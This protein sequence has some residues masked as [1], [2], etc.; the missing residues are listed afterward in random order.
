MYDER[1]GLTYKN[2]FCAHCN[3]VLNSTF[4]K[5][6]AKCYKK[7][8]ILAT[9]RAPLGTLKP[10]PTRPSKSFK[11][12]LPTGRETDQFSTR[13][14][15][16]LSTIPLQ[17]QSSNQRQTAPFATLPPAPRPARQRT[18]LFS[19]QPRSR[20][21]SGPFTNQLP[22]QKRPIPFST[23]PPFQRQSAPL[24]TKPPFRQ[25]TGSFSIQS[26][27]NQLKSLQSTKQPN[28]RLQIFNRRSSQTQHSEMQTTLSAT[29][30]STERL[31]VTYQQRLTRSNSVSNKQNGNN[32]FD[33]NYIKKECTLSFEPL[34]H[35][36]VN[37]CIPQKITCHEDASQ[38]LKDLCSFYHLPLYAS[39][40]TLD[41]PHCALCQQQGLQRLKCFKESP[42]GVV[43][44]KPS[45]TIMF[46][47]SSKIAHSVSKDGTNFQ[48][49]MHSKTCKK[50]QVFDP[51]TASCRQ[52]APQT[53]FK[54]PSN[55][56]FGF[57]K[58]RIPIRMNNSEFVEFSNSTVFVYSHNKTYAKELYERDTEGIRLCI[59]FTS[60]YLVASINPQQQK[61][62]KEL[63]N[64]ILSELTF[65]GCCLSEVSLLILIF[66]YGIFSELRN[67][68]G[69]ILI[70]LACAMAIYQGVFFASVETGNRRRCVAIAGTLH[71]FLLV[72]F[73][74][75]NVL[76]FDVARVFSSEGKM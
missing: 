2:I 30:P 12:Q 33:M 34:N 37:H 27:T 76:A 70:S 32:V 28:H 74:W 42:P 47:F 11:T 73:T 50:G 63:G 1:S 39:N 4:W 38:L 16:L 13:L 56:F 8:T 60:N 22:N 61:R 21:S 31:L 71:Y 59:N 45:L 36:T 6:I 51:F 40:M 26:T 29:H 65:F 15:K 7:N 18:G 23:V 66:T 69:K 72:S 54:S 57:C 64:K 3:N 35:F 53:A 17:T 14:P 10:F 48:T 67:L 55:M 24:S 20:G 25:Q 5:F 58:G 52:V 44:K 43:I 68:P 9:T 19:A 62:Q 41:N 49:V 75:M 46:D